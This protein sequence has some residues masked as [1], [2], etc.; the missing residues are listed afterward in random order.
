MCRA[1]SPKKSS[2]TLEV[3]IEFR[4]MANLPINHSPGSTI[5][6]VIHVHLIVG[7]REETD[8]VTLKRASLTM[9]EMNIYFD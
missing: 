7:R 3:E 2:V 9:N 5:P 4:G 1:G 8:V 6:T